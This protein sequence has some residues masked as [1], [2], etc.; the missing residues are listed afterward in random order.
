MLKRAGRPFAWPMPKKADAE[1]EWALLVPVDAYG[2]QMRLKGAPMSYCVGGAGKVIEE[3]RIDGNTQ[4]LFL[5][6]G[7]FTQ[8]SPNVR[9]ESE[10]TPKPGAL[11]W[12]DASASKVGVA[13]AVRDAA[14][15]FPK[16]FELD[17]SGNVRIDLWKDDPPRAVLEIGSGYYRAHDLVLLFHADK[18]QQAKGEQARGLTVPARAVVPA[19][20]FRASGVFGPLPRSLATL[21]EGFDVLQ[22]TLV[23]QDTGG[24]TYL[25]ESAYGRTSYSGVGPDGRAGYAGGNYNVLSVRGALFALYGTREYMDDVDRMGRWTRDWDL[26]HRNLLDGIPVALCAEPS[27]TLIMYIPTAAGGKDAFP[28]Q[29][30]TFQAI[31]EKKRRLGVIQI[32]SWCRGG[33]CQR[34]RD[35]PLEGILYHYYLTGD[36]ASGETA[37]EA[38]DM[39]YW[40]GTCPEDFGNPRH[41]Y[42]QAGAGHRFHVG[43]K[44]MLNLMIAYES[45]GDAKYLDATKTMWKYMLDASKTHKLEFPRDDEQFWKGTSMMSWPFQAINFARPAW[46]LYHYTG[47]ETLKEYAGKLADALVTERWDA[48]HREFWKGVH[49]NDVGQDTI[50]KGRIY[51]DSQSLPV[52]TSLGYCYLLTGKKEYVDVARQ[53]YTYSADR[54]KEMKAAGKFSYDITAGNLLTSFQ[55]LLGALET[56]KDK[57]P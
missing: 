42:Y 29:P 51:L 43:G 49:T 35:I 26:K 40:L 48:Q 15:L 12:L 2:L 18:P 13:V 20:Q 34:S 25:G 19:D 37:R 17:G 36:P 57:K 50:V 54:Y 5:A 45:L 33:P 56:A 44:F 52:A 32:A 21:P 24:R 53:A 1:R 39:F 31:K 30:E 4:K 23:T 38:A 3:G 7:S 55:G 46:T 14:T 27:N 10:G 28:G 8:N 6:G 41:M 11:E 9:F 22:K 47:D 16:A